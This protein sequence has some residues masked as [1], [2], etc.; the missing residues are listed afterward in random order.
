MRT[1]RNDLKS[2][3]SFLFLWPLRVREED[4][5]TTARSIAN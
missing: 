1:A 5:H 3:A 2:I 4:F